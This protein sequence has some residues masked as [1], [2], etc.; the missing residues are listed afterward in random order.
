MEPS[1]M[2]HTQSSTMHYSKLI[3]EPVYHANYIAN[4]LKFTGHVRCTHAIRQNIE[5]IKKK[6]NNLIIVQ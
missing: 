4:I 6:Y 5:T 2:P 3:S 1:A